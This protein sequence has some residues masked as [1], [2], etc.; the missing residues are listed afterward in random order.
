MVGSPE[1]PVWEEG[2]SVDREDPSPG[3]PAASKPASMIKK[4]KESWLLKN[5]CCTTSVRKEEKEVMKVEREGHLKKN[6]VTPAVVPLEGQAAQCSAM[7]AASVSM[8]VVKE[9]RKGMEVGRGGHLYKN[10]AMP[11]VYMEVNREEKEEVPKKS[12]EGPCRG[13]PQMGPPV[14]PCSLFLS[15]NFGKLN[16]GEYVF[17]ALPPSSYPFEIYSLGQS[18]SNAGLLLRLRGGGSEED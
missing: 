2:G 16:Y 4:G 8:K 17:Y 14:L 18:E 13:G 3:L 12:K 7:P 9:E 10:G 6:V 1:S 11:A 15:E 5:S